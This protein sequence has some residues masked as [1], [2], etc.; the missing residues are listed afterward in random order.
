MLD[1]M[2]REGEQTSAH[3][4][5]CQYVK[6]HSGSAVTPGARGH[7]G[8]AARERIQVHKVTSSK[9]EEFKHCTHNM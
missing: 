1:G 3:K 5:P 7:V 9:P 4:L 6:A 8:G 2:G